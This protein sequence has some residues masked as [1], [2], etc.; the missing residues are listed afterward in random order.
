[1]AVGFN[2]I[3]HI[4][5]NAI[6]LISKEEFSAIKNIKNR[7]EENAIIINSHKNY[8]PWIMGWSQR[9]YINP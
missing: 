1:M 2:Y 9:D 8:T 4:N 3:V 7:T 6:P 5:I